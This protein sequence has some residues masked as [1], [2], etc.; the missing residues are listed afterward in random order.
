MSHSLKE[1]TTFAN[2][3]KFCKLI[4]LYSIYIYIYIF[5]YSSSICYFLIINDHSII[6][7]IVFFFSISFNACSYSFWSFSSKLFYFNSQ[8]HSLEALISYFCIP[9]TLQL[10]LICIVFSLSVY[11]VYLFVSNKH[12]LSASLLFRVE[13]L[14]IDLFNNISWYFNSAFLCYFLHI[15]LFNRMINKLLN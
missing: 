14:L 10:F 12:W 11:L 5:I 4:T 1:W 8:N 15:S 6:I 13:V 7:F 3:L 2:S 9:L